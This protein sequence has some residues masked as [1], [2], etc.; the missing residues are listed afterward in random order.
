MTLKY[1][2]GLVSQFFWLS[3]T[4]NV[5]KLKKEG[6]TEEEIKKICVDENLF[7]VHSESFSLKVCRYILNRLK[8]MDDELMDIFLTSDISTQKIINLF[9]IVKKDKLFFEFLFEVYREKYII[10]AKSL[11]KSDLNIFFNNK[12][13]QSDIVAN[14]REKTKKQL[15]TMYINY[16][17]EAN[18]LTDKDGEKLITPPILDP[19]LE[20]YLELNGD[21]AILKAITG[22]S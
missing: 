19:R 11:S 13:L 12:E 18:L 6:K 22:V 9:L 17:T 4:R 3:E 5:I 8:Y 2:A 15:I 1:S 16:M 20:N 14:W 7:G 10:G 21:V